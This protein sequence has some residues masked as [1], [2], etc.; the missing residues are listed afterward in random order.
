MKAEL[1]LKRYFTFCN[2]VA[3]I[4]RNVTALIIIYTESFRPYSQI[5]TLHTYIDTYI[6]G[7]PIHVRPYSCDNFNNYYYHYHQY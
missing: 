5:S 1:S 3:S 6:Q 2:C 7:G 4:K